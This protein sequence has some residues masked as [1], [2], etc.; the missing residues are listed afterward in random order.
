DALQANG[1][2]YWQNCRIDGGGDTILGRGPSFFNHCTITEKEDILVYLVGGLF[3]RYRERLEEARPEADG[4]LIDYFMFW[5]DSRDF[6]SL[7]FR[8]GKG[9]IFQE[10]NRHFFEAGGLPKGLI[11]SEG[12]EEPYVRAGLAGMTYE[13]LYIWMTRDLGLSVSALRGLASRILSGELF[14]E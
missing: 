4:F 14:R 7:L 3:G 2:C 11:S 8:R 6:L 9:G 12:D 10:A 13:L 1:S 5:G